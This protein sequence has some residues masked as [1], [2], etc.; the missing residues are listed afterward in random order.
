MTELSNLKSEIEFYREK[1]EELEKQI[2]KDRQKYYA[3][4]NKNQMLVSLE[5][6]CYEQ[7]GLSIEEAVEGRHW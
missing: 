2:E 4:E 1:V 3:M 6:Q 5:K 7:L